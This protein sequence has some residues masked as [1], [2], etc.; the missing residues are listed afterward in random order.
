MIVKVRDMSN[1]LIGLSALDNRLKSTSIFKGKIKEELRKVKSGYSGELNFDKHLTEYIPSYSHAILHDVCLKQGGVYFQMDSLLITPFCIF[2]FEVK[3]IGGELIF[4]ENPDCFIRELPNGER[5]AM[6]SPI[7]QL[8]RKKFFLRNWLIEK[9]IHV[10]IK[11]IVA[12]AYSNEI[13]LETIPKYPILF[14]YQIPNY[15]NTLLLKGEKL[16][17]KEIEALSLQIK[18]N[19]HVYNAFPM[20]D[21]W[22][23]GL[24]DIQLG[25]QCISCDF[26][27]MKVHYQKWCCPRCNETG[28]DNY[29]AT[30]KDWFYLVDRRMTN[31]QFRKFACISGQDVAKRLLKNPIIHL[32][33]KTRGSYYVLKT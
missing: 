1:E 24:Q 14:T 30:I 17:G 22:G 15:L 9:E 6:Q 20:M 33:G 19:H 4:K 31:R 11:P 10:P 13:E 28:K 29:L 32:K 2:I 26:F 25:V 21:K 16:T 7:A 3:N 18:T 8:E 12:L 5:K 23:I 27:G